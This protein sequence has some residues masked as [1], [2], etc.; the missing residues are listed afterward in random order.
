MCLLW[1]LV[2]NQLSAIKDFPQNR[3]AMKQFF[4]LT[5]VLF[6]LTLTSCTQESYVMSESESEALYESLEAH[7]DVA[8]EDN[9]SEMEATILALINEHRASQGVGELQFSSVAYGEA[10]KHTDYMIATG[11]LSHD[12]F[13]KRAQNIATQVKVKMVAENVAKEYSSS[14]EVVTYWLGSP[15]H[16]KSIEGNFTHTAI[17]VKEDAS[18]KLFFTQLFYR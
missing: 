8:G 16:R 18:G 9:L 5:G 7:A 1:Q 10:N 12:H 13:S 14:E 11:K 6:L 2:L 17:S 4:I 3:N 15:D